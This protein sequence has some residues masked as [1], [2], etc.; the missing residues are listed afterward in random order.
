MVAVEKEKVDVVKAPKLAR[1]P[2]C[3]FPSI[4]API[5]P[6]TQ[7]NADSTHSC[8]PDDTGHGQDDGCINDERISSMYARQKHS[9]TNA[10]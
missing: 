10:G 7:I 4:H 6:S 1:D 3:G 5:H 9:W 2:T 8:K